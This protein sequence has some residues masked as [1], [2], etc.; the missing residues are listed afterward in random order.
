MLA[1][2]IIVI[3][4]TFISNKLSKISG[5]LSKTLI[6]LDFRGF[7]KNLGQSSLLS[8]A[9]ALLAPSLKYLTNKLS[10]E[11]RISLT[12]YI[13]KRYLRSMMY[14]KTAY[15]NTDIGNP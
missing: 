7:M 15:L 13:H 6:E 1:L 14:Y 11:W 5:D 8:F 12:Q 3:S 9:S 2:A 4:R 10:L